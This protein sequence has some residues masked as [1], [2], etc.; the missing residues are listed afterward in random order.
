MRFLIEDIV[1]HAHSEERSRCLI[2]DIRFFARGICLPITYFHHWKKAV[3]QVGMDADFAT[4]R[5]A[6]KGLTCQPG[7]IDAHHE[8]LVEG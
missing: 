1:I 6:T 3:L 2:M 4:K 7:D 5:I 8:P